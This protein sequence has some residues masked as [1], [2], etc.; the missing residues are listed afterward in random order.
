MVKT[1]TKSSEIDHNEEEIV[2]VDSQ[3]ESF[4][5]SD[6]KDQHCRLRS[7]VR[8]VAK[9]VRGDDRERGKSPES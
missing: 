1:G 2:I 3:E 4:E 5:E 9:M 7:Q 6:N 8:K